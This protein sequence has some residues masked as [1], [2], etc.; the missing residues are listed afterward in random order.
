MPNSPEHTPTPIAVPIKYDCR[1]NDP[2]VVMTPDQVVKHWRKR[3]LYEVAFT[4]D[5]D[6]AILYGDIDVEVKKDTTKETKGF[7]AG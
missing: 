7:Y 6:L 4:S 5:D 2:D 3:H 1:G